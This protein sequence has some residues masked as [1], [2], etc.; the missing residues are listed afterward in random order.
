VNPILNYTYGLKLVKERKKKDSKE[1]FSKFS[2]NI[3]TPALEDKTLFPKVRQNLI[4]KL[5]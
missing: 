5:G 2:L 1:I 4:Q 3:T